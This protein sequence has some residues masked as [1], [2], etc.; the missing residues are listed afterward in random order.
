MLKLTKNV[1]FFLAIT[2]V[3]YLNSSDDL[4]CGMAIDMTTN[5]P[6]LKIFNHNGSTVEEEDIS[7]KDH[8][9]KYIVL[10]NKITNKVSIYF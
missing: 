1:V 4:D 9:K 6:I 2:E 7:R 3:G 10:R 5:R 8:G